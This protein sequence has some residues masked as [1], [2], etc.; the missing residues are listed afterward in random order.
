MGFEEEL[1]I[2]CISWGKLI[3]IPVSLYDLHDYSVK[4][5]V[6]FAGA[7]F[8]EADEES[9]YIA[10]VPKGTVIVNNIQN[11][12]PFEVMNQGGIVLAN[13][14]S[15]REIA[16]HAIS[17]LDD[18]LRAI[19]DAVAQKEFR[20]RGD[21]NSFKYTMIA[22]I[23]LFKPKNCFYDITYFSHGERPTEFLFNDKTKKWESFDVKAIG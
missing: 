9:S 10:G 13:R 15:I 11:A 12:S 18:L 6:K 14:Y 21:S 20:V 16:G 2:H 23:M 8:Y 17:N 4:R 5:I 7:F 1:Y 3:D 19:P 22:D